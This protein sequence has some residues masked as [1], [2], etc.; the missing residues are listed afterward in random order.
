MI[1]LLVFPLIILPLFSLIKNNINLSDLK[2][3]KENYLYLM[4]FLSLILTF[5]IKIPK[6]NLFIF[7]IMFILSLIK[8]FIQIKNKTIKEY[9]SNIFLMILICLIIIF[10][11]LL[12]PQNDLEG[13]RIVYSWILLFFIYFIITII[14][15]IKI[16]NEMV[17]RS[18]YTNSNDF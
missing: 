17:N 8:I 11:L 10:N 13:F 14:Y 1:I 9:Y 4:Y 12:P 15:F 5:Y 18:N 16:I 3:K 2:N 7:F 6:I